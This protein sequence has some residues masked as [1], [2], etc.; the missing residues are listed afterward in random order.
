MGVRGAV[1]L[2]L[3]LLH[4]EQRTLVDCLTHLR[5]DVMRTGH[6]GGH[7]GGRTLAVRMARRSA[8]SCNKLGVNPCGSQCMKARGS[9]GDHPWR[10]PT[11][12]L[13]C[14][15][16][17]SCNTSSIVLLVTLIRVQ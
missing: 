10:P 8:Y 6:I 16:I 1:G 17:K 9:I 4:I 13:D 2:L 3:G 12:L 14:S 11:S 5:N 7:I 15:G